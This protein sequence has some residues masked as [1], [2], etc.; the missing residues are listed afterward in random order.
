MHRRITISLDSDSVQEAINQI[1]EIQNDVKRIANELAQELVNDG[2]FIAK[3]WIIAY[4]AVETGDLLNS[5]EGFFDPSTGRGFI[6]ANS[7]HAAFVEYGTGI[8]GEMHSSESPDRPEGW[9]YDVNHHG[10]L[11]WYYYRGRW[12]KGMPPRPFMWHTWNELCEKAHNELRVRF[13]G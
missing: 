4:D 2:V 1:R 10:H 9:T 5:I 12:T 6:K 3:T 13:N 8:V 7:D 11:G